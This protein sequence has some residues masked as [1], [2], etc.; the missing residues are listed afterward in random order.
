MDV[1]FLATVLII[2]E[3]HAALAKLINLTVQVIVGCHKHTLLCL[4]KS[5][6]HGSCQISLEQ[7]TSLIESNPSNVLFRQQSL[8]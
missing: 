7:A 3:I 8:L 4:S 1:D 6:V 5:T 2:V